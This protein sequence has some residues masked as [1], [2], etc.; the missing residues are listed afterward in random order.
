MTWAAQSELLSIDVRN[1]FCPFHAIPTHRQSMF[2]LLH[3][4]FCIG[5][6]FRCLFWPSNVPFVDTVAC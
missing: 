4:R 5:R 2:L 6:R 1:I 3:C